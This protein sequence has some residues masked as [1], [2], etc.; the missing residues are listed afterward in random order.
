MPV[1]AFVSLGSNIDAE[2]QLQGAVAAMREE[3]GELELS[4]VYRSPAVGFDGDDFLNLIA[5]FVTDRSALDCAAVMQRLEMEAGRTGEQH[6]FTARP[7]D[8]DMV[9]YGDLIDGSRELRVPRDDVEK[10]AFV[11]GPLADIAPDFAH[12][13]TGQTMAQM[14]AEFDR[15]TSPMTVVEL[16]L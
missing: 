10:Y 4:P 11:L 15:S 3:F 5:G 6:G 13:V 9:L 16:S 1:R 12:P 8:L 7:L 14:W 2:A